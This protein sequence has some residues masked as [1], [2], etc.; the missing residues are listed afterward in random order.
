MGRDVVAG[1]N[2][3][4]FDLNLHLILDI[5]NLAVEAIDL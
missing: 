3:R 4:M 2:V 1:F 5:K